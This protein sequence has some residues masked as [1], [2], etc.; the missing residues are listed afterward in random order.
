[1][2]SGSGSPPS[3]PS[4]VF[5]FHSRKGKLGGGRPG[6]RKRVTVRR[7]GAGGGVRGETGTWVDHSG[8]GAPRK[9]RKNA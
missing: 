5:L 4:C 3:S 7:E 2:K 9:K 8:G 1:M 6:C